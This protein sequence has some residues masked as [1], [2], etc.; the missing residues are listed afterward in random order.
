MTEIF[1]AKPSVLR[2]YR[3]NVPHRMSEE[4]FWRRYVRHE[5]H[6]ESK[7]KARSEGLTPAAAAAAVVDDAGG[8]IFREAAA[9]LAAE[10][11]AARGTV[12][13]RREAVDPTLDL[14]ASEAERYTGH[15]LAHAATREPELAVAQAAAAAAGSLAGLEEPDDLAAVINRHGT[16]VLQ[17][18]EALAAVEAERLGGAA[19]GAGAASR[20]NHHHGQH[21]GPG[22]GSAAAGHHNRRHHAHGQQP[23]EDDAGGGGRRR[24][25]SAGLDDLHEPAAPRLDTLSI[26]DPRRYFERVKD[27]FG[28]GGGC[29]GGGGGG[30]A[31]GGGGGGGGGGLGSS[32]GVLAAVSPG[33]LPLPPVDPGAA[34]EALLEATP[35]ARALAEDE[36]AG[37]GGAPVPR[38]GGVG[39]GAGA[40]GLRD[41]ASS[42]PPETLA[43]LRRTVLAVNEA[44]RH[45]WRSLPA[46]T[47]AR[48]EKVGGAV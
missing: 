24:R 48:R 35:L 7:R 41:P 18:V 22:P 44:C 42:V 15:G 39:A 20:Q 11:A 31:W 30:A 37:P 29:G 19:A 23:G 16:V 6:K 1:A 28:G 46:N 32:A 21:A 43:F 14:A 9:A 25:H 3:Q 4:D 45:F 26:A 33:C 38:P 17:G 8:D 27:A 2:A 12:A 5:M 10:A 36:A 34:E 47:P 13:A 40:G